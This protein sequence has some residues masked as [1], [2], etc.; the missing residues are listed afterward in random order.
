ME[1]SIFYRSCKISSSDGGGQEDQQVQEFLC[2]EAT[3]LG[4]A[5]LLLDSQVLGVN[6][7]DQ[8][9]QGC[10]RQQE[11]NGQKGHVV[12]KIYCLALDALILNLKVETHFNVDTALKLLI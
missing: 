10:Q 4:Q 5:G 9:E 2:G 1:P 7:H 3:G 8:L 6:A 12:R 11:E